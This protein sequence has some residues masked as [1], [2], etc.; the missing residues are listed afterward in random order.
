MKPFYSS[1]EFCRLI[2]V[3]PQT[4]RNWDKSG[5]L[6]PHHKGSNGY[7]YYSHEQLLQ[8]TGQR[9]QK[10]PIVV[11]YC[12]VSSKK[13]AGDLQRQVENLQ[14]Y[15]SAQGKP[16][17]IIEDVGPGLNYKKKGL[18]EL[19]SLIEN[20]AVSKV[21]VLYKDRLVRYGFELI[22][23]I[24]S[25]HNCTIEVIDKTDTSEQQELVED[26]IQIITVFSCKLQG[27][28]AKRTKD[29][30]HDLKAGDTDAEDVQSPIEA[31]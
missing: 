23:L 10:E 20:N 25:M 7:R 31:E 18:L 28:R 24:A 15:L 22:E 12:R 27:R 30:L 29:L 6:I 19:I 5:K 26:L 2:S 9:L 14:L 8:V 17:R 1:R 13:Q 3:T 16:F 4:L 11:G 21:V